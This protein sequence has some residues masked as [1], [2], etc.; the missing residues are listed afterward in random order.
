[1]TNNKNFWLAQM[2]GAGII[3]TIAAVM[4]LQG[5]GDS[6]LVLV[7]GI[8]LGLHVLEIPLAFNMLK[9]RNAQPLRIIAMTFLFGLLWWIPARRG[10]LP[11]R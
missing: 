7:V 6:R 9:G 5:H 11:V 3:Y 1:M 4:C 8:I 2:I 10:I